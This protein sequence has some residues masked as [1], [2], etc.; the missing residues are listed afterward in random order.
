M[1]LTQEII[2]SLRQTERGLGDELWIIDAIRNYIRNGG[3][4]LA[5][6]VEDGQWITTGDP[7]SYLKATMEYALARKDINKDLRKYLAKRLA[8]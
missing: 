5:K 4:F 7:L 2:D 6:E 1:V 8:S 3:R